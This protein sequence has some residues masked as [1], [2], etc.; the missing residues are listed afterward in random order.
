MTD[1]IAI[2]IFIFNPFSTQ[3]KMPINKGPGDAIVTNDSEL[4]QKQFCSSFNGIDYVEEDQLLENQMED[5]KWYH[6]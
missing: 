6:N 1:I 2:S 4:Y 3:V 5:L